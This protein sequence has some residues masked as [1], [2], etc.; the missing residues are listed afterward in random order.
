MLSV[1]HSERLSRTHGRWYMYIAV[2]RR[3]YA[4]GLKI[5]VHKRSMRC[6]VMYNAED[7]GSANVGMT[8]LILEIPVVPPTT[9]P[10]HSPPPTIPLFPRD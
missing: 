4:R 10:H 6:P 2:R 8:L 3:V 5:I 7:G 1:E 9:I